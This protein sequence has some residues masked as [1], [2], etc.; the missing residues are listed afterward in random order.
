MGETKNP[1]TLY[2]SYIIIWALL[3]LW[4]FFDQLLINRFH[5]STKQQKNHGKN[6][7]NIPST[8]YCLVSMLLNYTHFWANHSFLATWM[9]FCLSGLLSTIA[10]QVEERIE[11]R[12]TT[13][14]IQTTPATRLTSTEVRVHL[15]SREIEWE[16]LLRN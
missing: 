8:K 2:P 7:F 1:A 5:N 11:E 13:K 10:L 15:H 9:Q 16:A 4:Y 6:C 14:K 12:I 3:T